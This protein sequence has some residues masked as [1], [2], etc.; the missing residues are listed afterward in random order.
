[1]C[2]Y[3]SLEVLKSFTTTATTR[4]KNVGQDILSSKGIVH[5]IHLNF[6]QKSKCEHNASH[7]FCTF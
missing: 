6:E 7:Y 3:T 5:A 2:A 1:M 4:F